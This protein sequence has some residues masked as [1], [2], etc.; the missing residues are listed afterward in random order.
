MFQTFIMELPMIKTIP[1]YDQ[2]IIDIHGPKAKPLFI[3]YEW[4]SIDSNDKKS[5]WSRAYLYMMVN[6]IHGVN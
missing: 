3:N 6:I 1:R 4:T 5:K 2:Y